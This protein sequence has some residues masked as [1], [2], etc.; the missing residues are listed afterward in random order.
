[1]TT[2]QMTIFSLLILVLVFFIWGRWRYDVVAVGALLLAVFTGLVP[3]DQAFSGF[4]HPAVITVAAVLMVSQG[5]M[6]AGLVDRLTRIV[7]RA[8]DHIVLQMVALVGL[9]TMA[10][11][12]MN[13]VGALA[14]LMPV[15]IRL[16]R[17]QERS[18]SVYLMP[19]AFGSL[20]GGMSTQIGTPPN[21]IVSLIRA[22]HNGGTAFRMFDFLPVGGVVAVAGVVFIILIGWRFIP[23]RKGQA[24]REDFFHI[25]DYISEVLIPNETDL[26][27]LSIS[28]LEE[29]SDGEWLVVAHYR[30]GQKLAAPS[31][32]RLLEGGDSI[33]VRSSAEKLNEMVDE[34][35]LKIAEEGNFDESVLQSEDMDVVEATIKLQ[36]PLI[37]R[38]VRSVRLRTLYNI[39]LLALSRS[40]SRIA[41]TLDQVPLK[42]G[43]V[44]LL[45]GSMDT[46]NTVLPLLGLLPLAERKIRIGQPQK[47]AFGLFIFMLAIAASAAGWI[48]VQVSFV[49]AACVMVLLGFLPVSEIYSSVDWPVIVLLGAILPVSTALETTG[50][51]HLLANALL[52]FSGVMAPASILGVILI[53]TM[54]LSNVVNNAAAALLMAP[55]AISV[56]QGIQVNVD[57]FLMAVAIGASSAFLTPIGHQSN[58]L[59]LGPGGYRFTD[60]W[61]LGLPLSILIVLLTVP[62]ILRIWPL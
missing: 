3:A 16:A 43:D 2:E 13:N 45:Q 33:L 61:K 35:H 26:I 52:S 49:A 50:G 15:A 62:L 23:Y 8:G 42:V 12:L 58:T 55:L 28:E 56:A 53:A 57:P 40:G 18:P 41:V 17:K 29:K 25:D 46:M 1:M 47:A 39:N 10:S 27:G 5:L 51:A 38:T 4:G 34:Y 48:P 54:L 20:L 24:S 30:N 59:V 6:N 7:S 31:S 11:S 44:L 21:I 60:Y 37:H 9:V 14:L 19:L 22:N 32:G 36:S